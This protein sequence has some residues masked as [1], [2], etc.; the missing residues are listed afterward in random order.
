MQLNPPDWVL[1]ACPMRARVLQR[2]QGESYTVLESF[3]HPAGRGVPQPALLD[4]RQ[5]PYTRFAQ[6]LAQ[7]LEAE[8]RQDHF[9]SLVLIAPMP[10]LD[11]LRAA[12]GR[13]ASALVKGMSER[14]LT[15]CGIA[16]LGR[17][18]DRELELA[19]H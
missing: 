5:K 12:L 14:D 19:A 7:Y 15:V 2:R 1:I 8:A 16:E 6:E 18:V 3:V 11:D 10:F 4:E 9:A 13:C 17:Q